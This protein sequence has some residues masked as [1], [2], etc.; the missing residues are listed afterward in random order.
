MLNHRLQ[1][2][3]L[4]RYVIL[5]GNTASE[6]DLLRAPSSEYLSFIHENLPYFFTP[7]QPGRGTETE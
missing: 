1:T 5:P 7:L 2:T 4:Y 3:A 6:L